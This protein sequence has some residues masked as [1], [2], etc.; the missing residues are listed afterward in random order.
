M[1]YGPIF[2]FSCKHLE[3]CRPYPFSC[4]TQIDAEQ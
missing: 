3:P 2:F 1:Q 4:T